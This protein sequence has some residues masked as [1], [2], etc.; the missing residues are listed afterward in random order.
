MTTIHPDLLAVSDAVEVISPSRYVILGEARDAVP[1]GAGAGPL[2]AIPPLLPWAEPAPG[3]GPAVSPPAVA[4]VPDAPDLLPLLERELYTRL[5]ARACPA[6]AVAADV[7]ALRDHLAALSAANNGRGSWEPGW[8]IGGADGEGRVA[9]AK[10]GLT[11]WA[12]PE[13][14][15]ARDVPRPGDRCRVRVPKEL[16][17]LAAGY[18]LAIGDGDQRDRPGT[19]EPLTRLYWHLTARAAVPYMAA[20]TATLNALH[21]PF[22]TKVLSDPN[23]YLRADA[24]VLY[25]ERRF[26]PLL[27]T[28]IPAIHRRIATDLR[29]QVPLF[30][31]PLA[32]GLGLAEDP[33]NGMSFGQHRCKL[34][35]LGLWRSFLQGDRTA[36]SRAA[37]LAAVFR[38]AGR[39]PAA[40]YLEPGSRDEY[41]FRSRRRASVPR[42]HDRRR[43]HAVTEAAAAGPVRGRPDI[44]PA[45]FLDV[46]A[47][48]GRALCRSAYWDREGRCCNWMGRSVAD[49]SPPA[50]PITPAA[51]ALGPEL[52]AG[53]VG[54]AWFLAQLWALTGEGECRRTALGAVARSLRQV[55]R[56]PQQALPPLSYYCGL[57]GLAYATYRVAVL[58]GESALDDQ[59]DVLLAQIVEA[60]AQPHALDVIGGNAGAIPALLDLS[61][62]GRWRPVRTLAVWLGEELC[63]TAVRQGNV[64]VWEPERACGP[65][66][67]HPP[68]TGFAHGQSGM[69][70]ALLELHAATGRGEFLAGG[71]AAL[72]YEAQF[73]NPHKGNWPDLRLRE[74]LGGG[75]VTDPPYA[76]A[77]C[78]GAPGIGLARL[79][80]LSL[81]P[82]SRQANLATART[83]LDTTRAALRQDAGPHHVDASLCHGQAGLAEI[84]L[85]AGHWLGDKG[86]DAVARAAGAELIRRHAGCGDWPSGVASRGPNPS[87]MLGT[88]GIGYHFLRQYDPQ[89]VPSLLA[90]I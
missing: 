63:R 61:R 15:R 37:T 70:L 11:F 86:Y 16:R 22:R 62:V 88:A 24:A 2:S 1:A 59:V 87:L 12:P 85:T 67:G 30:T 43:G 20:V 90:V 28:A 81:D 27:G 45:T 36:E 75:R 21:V 54:V 68:L 33:H 14:L 83:A 47:G 13:G 53:S 56:S 51:A 41:A 38:E 8:V 55:G 46:A 76:T 79:R 10:D 3:E 72:A 65:G 18:Y 7:L 57:V 71:R 39:D 60:T 5:Y 82:A 4:P 77:W 73:F 17:H 40:P 26:C 66:A 49:L 29:P 32:R 80:A 69:G 25:L 19:P 42:P 64:W 9:V 50:V 23:M 31:K 74:T 44:S 78:H 89:R 58:T 34:M 52:Y 35:A 6:C 48:I 84:L